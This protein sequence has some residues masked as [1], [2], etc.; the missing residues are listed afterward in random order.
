MTRRAFLKVAA[1]GAAATSAGGCV[2]SGGGARPCARR[3]TVADTGC[4][5]E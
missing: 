5:F 1:M 4:E 3:I 2:T